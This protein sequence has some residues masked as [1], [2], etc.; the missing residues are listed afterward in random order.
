MFITLYGINNIGKSTHAKLLVENLQKQGYEAEYLK[1]PIYDLPPTGPI[2]DEIMRGGEQ[3]ISEEELQ[4]WFVLNR[5]QYQDTIVE[6]LKKG[7]IVVAEDY[8]G[9]AL[10]WGEAKGADPVWLENINKHLL[11]PDLTIMMNGERASHSFEDGHIHEQDDELV[12]K[13]RKI[14]IKLAEK[15]KW[16]RVEQQKKKSDTQKLILNVVKKHLDV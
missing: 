16:E 9:T 15:H 7:I 1:Y 6:M 10:A 14:F 4:L 5:H 8:I 3:E 2:I 13:V 12:S 11:E